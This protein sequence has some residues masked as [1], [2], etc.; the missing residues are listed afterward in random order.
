MQTKLLPKFSTKVT[1]V[2]GARLSQ[3]MAS[4]GEKGQSSPSASLL[5]K[6]GLEVWLHDQLWGERR[7]CL[8]RRF[9]GPGKEPPLINGARVRDFPHPHPH[10]S[11]TSPRPK[12]HSPS[13]PHSVSLQ[14]Q[15]RLPLS[16]QRE[17]HLRCPKV[18]I[19]QSTSQSKH[20]EDPRVTLGKKENRLCG[21]LLVHSLGNDI[22]ARTYWEDSA[23]H[24]CGF[25]QGSSKHSAETGQVLQGA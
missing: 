7:T 6:E 25:V 14:H 21:L 11:G 20:K 4:V 15:G 23:Q 2:T 3:L 24:N 13:L 18:H 16:L 1:V 5:A 8:P 9:W 12:P 19:C 17:G 22:W 10:P